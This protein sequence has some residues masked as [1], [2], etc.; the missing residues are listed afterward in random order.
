MFPALPHRCTED[1]TFKEYHIPKGAVVTGNIWAIG[2]NLDVYSDPDHFNPG[3]FLDPSVPEAL[4]F[5]FGRRI[6][7]G[8]HQ[9][10]FVIFITVAGL[11]AMLDIRPEE[12]EN[13]NPIPVKSDTIMNEVHWQLGYFCAK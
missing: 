11:L 4:I 10:E 9:A 7:P 12:V 1:D 13:G 5:G 3:R 8:L 2:N 6:C